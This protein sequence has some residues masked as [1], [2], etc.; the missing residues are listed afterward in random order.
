MRAASPWHSRCWPQTPSLVQPLSSAGPLSQEGFE[1]L[2]VT[3]EGQKKAALRNKEE[4]IGCQEFRVLK[5]VRAGGP[6][7]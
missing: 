1:D 3:S 5:A 6:C 7:G 2:G 4:M